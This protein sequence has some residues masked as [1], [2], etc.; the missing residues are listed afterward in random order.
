MIKRTIKFI[1]NLRIYLFALILVSFL[2]VIGLNP[3]DLSVF[4]SSKLGRA[5]GMSVSIPENPINKLAL[6]LKEKE[7]RLDQ[8]EQEL[9]QREVDID[10]QLEAKYN[11]VLVVLAVGIGVLFILILFNYYLDYRRRKRQG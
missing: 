10:K 2:F 6:Q 7:D 8:R 4:V 9:D 1:H 11:P 3:V 5:V